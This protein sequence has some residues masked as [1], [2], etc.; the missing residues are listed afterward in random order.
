MATDHLRNLRVAVYDADG[1]GVVTALAEA[2]WEDRLQLAGDG[3]LTALAQSVDGATELARECAARLRVREWYGDTELV[4]QLDAALGDRATPMLRALPI[5]L[6]ELA[7]AIEGD[8]LQGG[9]RIDLTTGQVIPDIVI[10]DGQLE[11]DEDELEDPDRWLGVW[12]EGSHAGYRDMEL[13]IESLGDTHLA[14]KLSIAIDG[15]GAFRRFK[16]VLYD[17]PENSDWYIFSDERHRGRARKWLAREGYRPDP[18][19]RPAL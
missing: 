17:Q 6:E 7:G 11:M 18:T 8:P 15:R 19:V 14:E 12:C 4:E 13:F 3:L 9:A 16:N 10:E 2:P 5:D 1:A